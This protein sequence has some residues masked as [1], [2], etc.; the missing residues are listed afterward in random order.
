MIGPNAPRKREIAELRAKI[1]RLRARLE[2]RAQVIDGVREVLKDVIADNERL[3]GL[4]G[5]IA[6]DLRNRAACGTL[7]TDDDLYA[8]LLEAEGLAVQPEPQ[9]PEHP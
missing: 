5:R 4:L 2:T 6:D 1:E 9:S 8:L 3:R 7:D